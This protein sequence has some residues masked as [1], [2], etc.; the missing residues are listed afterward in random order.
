MFIVNKKYL[1]LKRTNKT[2]G[3]LLIIVMITWGCSVGNKYVAPDPQVPMQYRDATSYADTIN[4]GMLP[5][6]DFFSDQVLL[7]LIDST[8][9]RNYDLQ[10]AIKNIEVA[11]QLVMQ[12]KQGYWPSVDAQITAGTQKFSNNSFN[13]ALGVTHIE[14]FT[15]GIGLSWE[16]DIWGKVSMRKQ[17]ALAN[18]LQTDEVRKAIQTRLVAEVA[19]GYYN[20]LS[21][22]EQ[23][24]V[25]RRNL[26]L[27]DSTLIII[28]LQYDAGQV[29]ALA[30]QQSD[31]QKQSAAL[32]IPAL[33]QQ[34][35]IQENALRV[36]SGEYPSAIT[37]LSDLN[38]F[39]IPDQFS[40]G[41]PADM[42][43]FRPDVKASELQLQA[44]NAR[45]GIA[46]AN[47][48]P[49]FVITASGGL[50]S[51]L[52]SS[53]FSIP[54]SLFGMLTG[55]VTQPIF[56]KRELKTEYEIAKIQ[57]EKSVIEFRQSV[58]F[59][60]EEVSNALVSVEKL[61]LQTQ[62]ATARADTLQNVTRNAM[63]LFRS[64]MANY[65]D[66]VTA[67]AT[68]LQ[69]QLDVVDVRRQ[70]INAYVEL[71]RSLGGGAQ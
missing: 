13:S 51:L 71:Y 21:L 15:A 42:V 29:N 34:I 14:N 6:H 20:L 57:R 1:A 8:I 16:A 27:R 10:I 3:L 45:V 49:S 9:K 25:A 43:R 52:F 19:Q 5:L 56:H 17:V 38:D 2:S 32:L 28:R 54:A 65:L 53:W 12:S 70:Q 33:E 66:V 64:G 11:N 61:K 7:E 58:L 24:K 68:A 55:S 35:A 59:A 46:K 40:A 60:V 67:Q 47:M 30:V 48:Y 62:I 18:Y 31:A 44:A 39:Q 41:I 23:L 26:E 69:S 4:V 36:I 50:N 63:L 22:D 37:V